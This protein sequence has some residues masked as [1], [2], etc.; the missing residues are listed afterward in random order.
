VRHIQRFPGRALH[1]RRPHLATGRCCSA[2]S[3]RG[4]ERRRKPPWSSSSRR[5]SAAAVDPQSS[6]LAAANRGRGH[7]RSMRRGCQGSPARSCRLAAGTGDGDALLRLHGRGSRLRR[8][9][10]DPP[11]VSAGRQQAPEIP[12]PLLRRGVHEGGREEGQGRGMRESARRG[13]ERVKKS[14]SWAPGELL[15]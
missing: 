6:G 10:G 12:P 13:K 7:P 3:Q 8:R 15:V 1:P 14:D 2:P 5:R 9:C 11:L 4:E